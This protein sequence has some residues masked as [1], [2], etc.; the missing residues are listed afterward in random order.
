MF[1][2]YRH[3][4]KVPH[5]A[6]TFLPVAV[7]A[8]SN[9]HNGSLTQTICM[10]SRWVGVC[11]WPI[12]ARCPWN[13]APMCMQTTAIQPTAVMCIVRHWGDLSCLTPT[14][15]ITTWWQAE[16]NQRWR[17]HTRWCA[18]RNIL[19]SR[20]TVAWWCRWV[21]HNWGWRNCTG[22]PSGVSTAA[23]WKHLLIWLLSQVYYSHRVLE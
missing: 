9:E 12:V 18:A 13:G 5:K 22:G 21:C 10:S 7:A 1:L 6:M 2:Y 16:P 17:H 19:A 4:M 23:H 8:I 14:A 3:Q 15:L 20:G 11:C